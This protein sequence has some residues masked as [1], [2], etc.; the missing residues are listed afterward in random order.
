[1][2]SSTTNGRPIS[3]VSIALS[4]LIIG[5]AE[6]HSSHRRFLL[7]VHVRA[8]M[9]RYLH[10][11]FDSMHMWVSGDYYYANG[12]IRVSVRLWA[13]RRAFRGR[14][15]LHRSWVTIIMRTCISSALLTAIVRLGRAILIYT[16]L[17]I[18]R[19]LESHYCTM[20]SLPF[21]FG[22]SA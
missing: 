15:T 22:I 4:N 19:D 16:G 20:L 5:H 14:K 11:H 21:N 18:D 13:C 12:D 9:Y 17:C 2:F 8:A 6:T 10:T 7:S 1:M 3:H